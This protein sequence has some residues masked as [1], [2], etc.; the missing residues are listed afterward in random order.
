MPLPTFFTREMLARLFGKEPRDLRAMENAFRTVANNDNAIQTGMNDGD[1]QTANLSQQPKADYI[2][3]DVN[4]P[5]LEQRGRLHWNTFEDTLNIGHANGV[6]QQVGQEQYIFGVNHSGATIPNGSVVG[7]DGVNGFDRVEFDKYIADGSI[8][9]DQFYGLATEEMLDDATGRVTVFGN[10]RNIDTTGT[11]VGETWALG[12][13]LYASP[14]TAGALTKVK[15]TAPD[16]VI[17]VGVVLTV[18]ATDGVIF[19]NPIK[20]VDKGYGQ[21]ENTL[22]QV[23]TAINTPKA[24]QHTT[25]SISNHVSLTGL[26]PTRLTV[27]FS[28][29]YEI[30]VNLTLKSSNASAKTMQI[31]FRKN[32]TDIANTNSYATLSATNEYLAVHKSDFFSLDANDYIEVMFSV[33]DTNLALRATAATAYSPAG[34]SSLV[35]VT[36][37]QQ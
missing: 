13:A 20:I 4:A 10:V 17:E 9:V 7:F 19:V 32:G 11:P 35:T 29:L 15:P 3:F 2:D 8:D 30:S 21:F 5:T 23:A 22:D 1:N 33:S 27:D 36:Q 34:T 26:P 12:D 14:T 24:V 25:A 18:S 37:V 31:W 16:H 6:V 28:G